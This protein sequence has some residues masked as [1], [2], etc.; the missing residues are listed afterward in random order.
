MNVQKARLPSASRPW[1]TPAAARPGLMAPR[2][3]SM[4][5]GSLCEY[6]GHLR[7]RWVKKIGRLRGSCG[8]PREQVYSCA[9]LYSARACMYFVA[10]A[11]R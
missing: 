2:S 1:L 6:M 4:A 10:C 7:Y 3:A 8:K 11:T 9:R 5:L